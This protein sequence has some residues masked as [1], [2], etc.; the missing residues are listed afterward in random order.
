MIGTYQFIF[1]SIC[2]TFPFNCTRPNHLHDVPKDI[3]NSPFVQL[4][5]RLL[6][7]GAVIVPIF[8]IVYLMLISVRVIL[9]QV[10][11]R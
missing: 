8:L 3:F 2:G 1:I 7:S 4:P 11:N 9:I 5:S 10:R 6:K